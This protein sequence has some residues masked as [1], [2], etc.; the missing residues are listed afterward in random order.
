[1]RLP[2]HSPEQTSERGIETLLVVPNQMPI[3]AARS[4]SSGCALAWAPCWH[5]R[6]CSMPMDEEVAHSKHPP[7]SLQTSAKGTC[8]PQE[9]LRLLQMHAEPTPRG[10]LTVLPLLQPSDNPR[11]LLL[12][13]SGSMEM[14]EAVH[15]P[16]RLPQHSPEQTSERGI[17]TLLVVP[18]QMPIVA[19]RSGS[20]LRPCS[21][22]HCCAPSQTCSM[23]MDEEAARRVH[24]RQTWSIQTSAKGTC[25]PWEDLLWQRTGKAR[26]NHE[27]GP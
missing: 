11:W 20:S 27:D 4:C 22:S 9:V 15:P 7:S 5:E 16:M 25:S 24:S 21:G 23:Q 12:S 14:D 3:V 26:L 10:T 8:S 1:M 13:Q 17:E 19:A 2:Q 6:T 18:N